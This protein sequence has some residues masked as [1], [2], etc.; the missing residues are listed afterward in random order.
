VF[1]LSKW[2]PSANQYESIYI[3]SKVAII[4]E[5]WMTIG[6]A[7]CGPRSLEYDTELNAF[8]NDVKQVVS[9]RKELWS[10]HLGVAKDDDILKNPHRAIKRMA[11]TAEANG[12]K[13]SGDLSGR[14]VPKTFDLPPVWL[15]PHYERIAKEFF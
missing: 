14:L 4:D 2:D 11:E 10:E 3:H 12:K 8:T 15:R 7:N 5:E 1:G 9:F 13:K 6:S